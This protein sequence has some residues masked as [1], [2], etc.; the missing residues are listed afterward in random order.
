MIVSIAFP[1]G[2]IL[3]GTV[4]MY[5]HDFRYVIRILYAPG[6]L[7]VIYFWIIPES[8]RWLLVTGRVDRA[9]RNLKRT[10]KINRKELSQKSIQMIKSKYSIEQNS[11]CNE[12]S[13]KSATIIQT[14]QSIFKSKSLL[15]RFL[16]CCFQFITCCFCLYGLSITALN[17]PGA[18]RYVSFIY[19][20]AAEIPGVLTAI[21]LLKRMERRKLLFASFLLTATS[22]FVTPFIPTDK[23]ILILIAFMV[24]KASISCTFNVVYVFCAE[25]WPTNIR[26]TVLNVCSMIGRIGSMVAPLTAVW[27]MKMF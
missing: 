1:M 27:V 7:L 3:L 17:I 4:A 15:G 2:E 18:N 19:V 6:L 14:F 10:A 12:N 25:L 23:S 9:I 16:N 21:P 5:V 24:A 26:T 22:I 20:V 13:T 11:V 8:I